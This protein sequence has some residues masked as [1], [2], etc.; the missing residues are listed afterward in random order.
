MILW[1]TKACV[2]LLQ[3]GSVFWGTF[4]FESPE[5]DWGSDYQRPNLPWQD[6]I[7]YE[8][9]VRSFT[10]DT[11]SK[12]DEGRQGTFLGLAD[13]VIVFSSAASQSKLELVK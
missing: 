7:V 2:H 5:F 8:M 10:A 3:Q 4:D 1:V 13:K 11:S 6:L 9:P 12:V